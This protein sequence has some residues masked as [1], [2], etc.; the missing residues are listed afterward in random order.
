MIDIDDID[1]ETYVQE[2]RDRLVQI[3]RHSD[4]PFARACAWT[5]LD[6]YTPD[7]EIDELHDELDSVTNRRVD[8]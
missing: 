1:P 7:R 4:D 8:V 2:N 3:I 6:R 5:M